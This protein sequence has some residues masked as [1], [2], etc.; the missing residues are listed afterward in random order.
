MTQSEKKSICIILDPA[1]GK[2]V[3]GKKSPSG[4]LLEY[5]WSRMMCDKLMKRLQDNGYR[6]IKITNSDEEIGLGNRV[7]ICTNYCNYFGKSNTLFVSLHVN[8]SPPMDGKWHSASGWQCHVCKNASEKSKKFASL[9]YKAIEEQGIK[10]RRPKKSQ[11][12]WENDYYVLKKTPCPATLIE[13]GFMDNKE[14]C[15]QLLTKEYQDKL[16]DAYYNAIIK[17]VD[18]ITVK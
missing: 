1:H 5:A 9:L 18:E 10:T 13:S 17:Y 6:C 12:Y 3:A 8:A 7:Q 4:E 11:D 14:E 16:L 2:S 15:K